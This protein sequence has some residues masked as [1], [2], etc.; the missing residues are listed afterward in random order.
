MSCRISYY[1]VSYLYVSFRGLITSVGEE[2]ESYFSAFVYLFLC[3]FCSE[4]F[5]LPLGA[6]D[7]LRYFIAALPGPSI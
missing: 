3:C 6:W 4:G 5:P 1:V 7:R 2:R